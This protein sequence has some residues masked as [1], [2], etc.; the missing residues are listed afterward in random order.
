M[1]HGSVSDAH[2]SAQGSVV[3][4]T[5]TPQRRPPASWKER[6][7][8]GQNKKEEARVDRPSS[9]SSSSPSSEQQPNAAKEVALVSFFPGFL[10]SSFGYRVV[11]K[12]R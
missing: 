4:T 10:F 5:K 8:T 12:R 6:T 2:K 7:K 11:F 1:H 9:S 3:A